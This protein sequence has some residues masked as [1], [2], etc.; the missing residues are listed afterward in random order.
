MIRRLIGRAAL[1]AGS[2]T[3]TV[4]VATFAVRWGLQRLGEMLK[5]RQDMIAALDKA[6]ADR[7]DAYDDMGRELD[8]MVTRAA[9]AAAAA[10]RYPAPED[11]APLH[12][13]EGDRG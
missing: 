9:A 13:E 8:E 3:V 7:Q 5:H 10:D 12:A 4:F 2:D 11:L 1:A 6:I